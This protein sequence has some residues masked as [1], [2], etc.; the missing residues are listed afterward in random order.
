MNELLEL[1]WP[2]SRLGEAIEILSRKSGFLSE[3]AKTPISLAESMLEDSGAF[4][5]WLETT[6]TGLGIEIEPIHIYYPEVEEFI[7]NAG[8]AILQIEGQDKDKF[9]LLL[10]K[11]GSKVSILN[12]TLA[13]HTLTPEAIRTMLCHKAEASIRAEV[14]RLL[15]QIAVSK[16][17]RKR[18]QTAIFKERLHATRIENCW[19]L[20]LPAGANVFQQARKAKLPGYTLTFVGTY[21]FQYLLW[22][23]SWWLLG[24]GVLQIGF[25]VAWFWAWVLL[26]LTLIPFRLLATWSQSLFALEAGIRLKQRFLQ[27]ALKL[28]PD[29]IRHQGVGQLLGRVIESEAVEFLALSGGF[30]ALLAIIE[31]IVAV[32][33]L[34]AGSG[35]WGQAFLL[36]GWLGLTLLITVW[37]FKQR[38]RWTKTRLMMTHDLVEGMVGHRTRLAQESP[39]NRHKAEDQMLE[40][41]LTQSVELDRSGVLIMALITHGWLVIGLIG[42]APAFVTGQNSIVGLVVGFGGILLAYRGFKNLTQGLLHLVGAVVAWQQVAPLFWAATRSSASPNPIFRPSSAAKSKHTTHQQPVIEARDLTF[43]YRDRGEAVLSGCDFRIYP[44]ERILL[45]GPSG[46]GKSTLASI[47]MGLRLP[48]SGLLLLQGLDWQTL[49]SAGWR[50]H[51]VAAPQFHENHIL[52]ET[53]AFN[54]LMGRRWPPRREDVQE[55]RAI[56]YELGLGDLLE[57]MPAGML[58]M[59]GET[60]WQLSHGEKSRLYIARTLLQKAD[61]IV[62]DESFA[63]LDPENLQRAL[64]CVLKR[65]PTLLVIAHP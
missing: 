58:Q 19:L 13:K 48:E 36:L 10:G 57:R 45:E 35:G 53:F 54:L 55:A 49:G 40:R 51:V 39:E 56:C 59:V 8:P 30:L 28:K 12:P 24:R 61:L 43:R 63:A 38:Q 7:K 25:D 34:S 1:T 22:I 4:S 60:G 21:G 23:L 50:H 17:R 27:G 2:I 44:Q 16:H 26:L 29:E 14:D 37:H 47:L 5:Q 42:L 52:T 32:F 64:Q 20:R 62:L 65:S 6:A 18:T 9:L 15:D 3:S 41:Y 11:K 31:L 33:I 46:G